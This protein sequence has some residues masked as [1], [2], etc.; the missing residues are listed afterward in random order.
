MNRVRTLVGALVALAMG[1]A[2]ESHDANAGGPRIVV[3]TRTL[4]FRHDSIPAA[5]AAMRDIAA[6]DGLAVV[7]TEDPSTFSPD[8]LRG[9][10][11]VV[12]LHTTGEVL[13]APGQAALQAYVRGGGGFLGIHS[14][15]DTGHA[16]PWY[17]DLLGAEFVGH[18]AIQPAVLSREDTAHP[19]TSPLPDSW[20][21]TDEWY[22]FRASPR[23]NVRVL[24][25]IDETTYQGGGMGRDHPMA[26]CHPFEGGRS[27]YT[28]L[29]HTAESWSEPL[30]LAHV[31]GALR[32]AAGLAAGD[33]GH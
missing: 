25:S 14:A 24:L 5:V 23:P 4:G 22:D 27:A 20:A 9:V 21:R 8:K 30:Y 10:S 3:F 28:A 15:A 17:L 29:G 12:F 32:W 33:C 19:A 31:R 13:D 1:C 16:W 2:P 7:A 18:P 6:L 11:A 26:W